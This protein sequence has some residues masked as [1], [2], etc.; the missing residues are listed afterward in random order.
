MSIDETLGP[1]SMAVVHDKE[2]SHFAAEKGTSTTHLIFKDGS[3]LDFE[4]NSMTPNY[5]SIGSEQS[6]AF[7][8]A[9]DVKEFNLRKDG[10]T[11]VFKDRSNWNLDMSGLL[12]KT[13]QKA[14]KR[15]PHV[16]DLQDELR[17]MP[18]YELYRSL[19]KLHSSIYIFDKNYSELHDMIAFLSRDPRARHLF[20]QRNQDQL[21]SA[22]IEVI[23]LLHNYVAAAQSLIDH[24]RRLHRK[25][26][27]TSAK[28]KDYQVRIKSDFEH[29]TLSQFIKC[30]RQYCQHYKAPNINFTVNWVHTEATETRTLNLLVADLRTF[31][32]WSPPARKFLDAAGDRINIEEVTTLYR[33]KVTAFYQWFYSRQ[34]EIHAEELKR[35]KQKDNELHLLHLETMIDT[36]LNTRGQGLP[37]RKEDAFLSI[38]GSQEI[39]E[40]ASDSSNAAKSA[41]HAIELVEKYLPLS[42]EIK[43]KIIRLYEEYDVWSD[44]AP[45]G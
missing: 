42:D 17:R 6:F 26:S 18:E 3:R 44:T 15:T 34:A 40:L 43:Q 35:V 25:L 32:G 22:L 9:S 1:N 19:K 11:V 29:D 7:R 28:F 31:D 20:W 30:L 23:R 8:F 10:F 27:G 24:T 36:I 4:F 12:P 2:F 14:G 39:E 45:G 21:E 13:S 41:A 16:L 5:R 37:F 33:N 38:L